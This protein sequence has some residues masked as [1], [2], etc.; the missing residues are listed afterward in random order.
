MPDPGLYVSTCFRLQVL[1]CRVQ[2]LRRGVKVFFWFGISG[3]GGSV[4]GLGLWDVG[5]G[6]GIEG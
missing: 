6:W 3:F 5:L 4:E 1:G 2:G